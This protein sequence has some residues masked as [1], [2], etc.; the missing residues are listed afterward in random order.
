MH[1]PMLYV[2]WKQIRLALLPFTVAAFGLPLL[3]V[4][5]VG[6]PL[7]PLLV[8]Q[9]AYSLVADAALWLPF[10]PLLAT[11]IGITLALSAWNWDHQIKH[12]YALSLP[13]SRWEYAM[14]KM[15]AGAVL[16]LL[17]T[18]ALWVG[19]HVA[20]LSVDLPAGLHAYPNQLAARFLLATLV[21]YSML[22]A[23]AA[24]TIKTTV[25]LFTGVAIFVVGGFIVNDMLAYQHE[26]FQRINVVEEVF[27]WLWNAP[28]P[29]EV[30]SGNW[31]LI[32]V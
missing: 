4:Q 23:M 16:A 29:L 14:L 6:T 13:V 3:V 12:V 8:R 28:G 27:N 1:Q 10:F 9:P 30:F 15:G 31:S 25:W 17:P 19:A 2:H 11:A 24:G 32:D 20:A 5:G 21:S 18:T 22:F 26:F 7:S